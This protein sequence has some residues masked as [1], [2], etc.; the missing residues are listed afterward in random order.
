LSIELLSIA[1]FGSLILAVTLGLPVVFCLGG[2]AIGFTYF[3][4]GPKA[5]YM[6][7]TTYW[8]TS[9]NSIL[10]AVP[11]FIFMANM[12][13]YSGLADDLFQTAYYWLG[14][15]NGG[16][17]AGVVLI[18]TIFAAMTGTTGAAT[19]TMGLVALPAM[20][21]RNY[22]K[23]LAVGCIMAGGVLGILIP[24]SIIMIL[25]AAVSGESVGSLF[26]GGVFPGLILSSL[27]MSYVLIR[28]HFQPYLGPKIPKEEVPNLR[29]RFLSLKAAILPFLLI[30][31]VLGVIYSGVATPTEA[32]AVGAFGAALCTVIHRRFTWGV[33]NLALRKTFMLTA[34]GL[35][36]LAAASCFNQLYCAMGASDMITHLVNGLPL[37][38][39]AILITMQLSL[40][41]LGCLMDDWALLVLTTPIFLPIVRQLGFDTLWYGVLFIVNMQMAYLTPP[42]GFNIFYMKA[43]VPKDVTI[44][45]IYRSII[46]FV[47]LQATGLAI[48]MIFPQV[49]LWLPSVMVK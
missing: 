4:W 1:I 6:V 18:C 47:I 15:I 48:C 5:V 24:P 30:L 40:F 46:P 31:L 11:L 33:L 14:R 25:Y 43:I 32:S 22:D 13:Q 21:K 7:A 42:Y 27:F 35:W 34:M 10:M 3:L 38:R 39:W 23:E 19:V 28:S 49:V 16:L 37:S 9:S 26:M 12:L 20:L 17:A 44:M 45:D 41:V 29:E 8:A 2:V 36:L